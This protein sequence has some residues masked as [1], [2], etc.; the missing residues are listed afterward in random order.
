ML[1]NG[2][3][4]GCIRECSKILEE[5]SDSVK[6]LLRG[7]LCYKEQRVPEFQKAQIDLKRALSYT[8]SNPSLRKNL[9]GCMN[10]THYE[11]LGVEESASFHEI[12]KS[13]KRLAF[14]WHP[15]RKR[16][17]EDK[18]RA[19]SRMKI[20]NEAYAVLNSSQSRQ[21]Y[22]CELIYEREMC[23]QEL[24]ASGISELV[25]VRASCKN[26]ASKHCKN[27]QSNTCCQ[28]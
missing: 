15:D 27:F 7:H 13:Y 23:E 18:E 28:D 9:K 6:A 24:F 20:I 4:E 5:D 17:T 16:A 22:N 2:S 19:S 14:E 1:K 26:P 12:R 3:F 25:G 11:V 8:S 21:E 10:Q